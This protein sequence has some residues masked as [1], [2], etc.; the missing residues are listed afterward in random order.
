MGTGG[1]DGLEGWREM[2]ESG[3]EKGTTAGVRGE[4]GAVQQDRRRVS[5]MPRGSNMHDAGSDANWAM[6][7]TGGIQIRGERWGAPRAVGVCSTVPESPGIKVIWDSK[8]LK[9]RVCRDYQ[10]AGIAGKEGEL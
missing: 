7:Q 5:G 9:L 6:Q 8:L 3:K 4:R 1:T 10:G 2:S